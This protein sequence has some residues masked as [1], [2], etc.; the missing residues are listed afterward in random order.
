[1]QVYQLP[2]GKDPIFLKA[3]KMIIYSYHNKSSKIAEYSPND[4]DSH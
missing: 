2:T 1:M 4:K 3:R